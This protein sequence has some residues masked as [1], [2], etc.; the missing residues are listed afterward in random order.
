MDQREDEMALTV[1]RQVAVA[2]E[3]DE[4]EALSLAVELG[5][6]LLGR[7]L[8]DGRSVAGDLVHVGVVGLHT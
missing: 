6:E 2:L 8:R 5:A 1:I 3:G 7:D 4:L